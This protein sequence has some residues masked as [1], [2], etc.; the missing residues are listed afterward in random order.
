[1]KL[2]ASIKLIQV[3]L[4]LFHVDTRPST[5]ELLEQLVSH[6]QYKMLTVR[7]IPLHSA[8]AK[9]YSSFEWHGLLKHLR[10][11]LIS[12]TPTEEGGASADGCRS[13]MCIWFRYFRT[14]S[15]RLYN[16]FRL[17]VLIGK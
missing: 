16:I 9:D 3:S 8:A 7:S 13:Y 11:M 17:Q 2:F 1:M 12:G 5:G 14:V 10:Q 4:L 15:P 6:P